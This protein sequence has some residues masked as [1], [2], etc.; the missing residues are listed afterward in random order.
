[1]S[2]PAP[3]YS[4]AYRDL[5]TRVTELVRNTD[6]TK[7]DT[8]APATPDWRV[9]D[10]VAHMAGVCD[11]VAHGNLEGVASD[12]WTDAQVEKR[13]ELPIDQMLDEWNEHAAQVEATMNERGPQVGQ[14][15]A[16]AATH[17]Q[18][19]R[20]ALGV[21]GGRESDAGRIGVEW[22]LP[23]LGM[24]L[25]AEGKG[26]LRIEHEGGATEIGEG[27]PVTRLRASRFELIRAMTGRRSLAQMEA[28]DWDG[29]L[30]RDALVLAPGLFNPPAADL[31]E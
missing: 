27:E 3:D 1:V 24:R 29:P 18:D 21:P 17:E 19:I 6:E 30:E 22:A 28:L 11:D 31:V 25:A 5:R 15:L 7:L 20:G 4:S 13:R 23:L 9:R 8:V 16:D 12:S 26:T 2:D 10:I 14:M